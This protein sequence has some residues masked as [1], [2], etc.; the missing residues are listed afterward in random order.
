MELL[1]NS[2]TASGRV[3]HLYLPAA[4]LS[5]TKFQQMLVLFSV[6][7]SIC[8]FFFIFGKM[9]FL[10]TYTLPGSVT[11]YFEYLEKCLCLTFCLQNVSPLIQ[12]E[13]FDNVIQL[14]VCGKIILG[15]LVLICLYFFSIKHFKAYIE[16]LCNILVYLV[17]FFLRWLE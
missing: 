5:D 4:T 7:R 15:W 6:C 13:L 9:C 8:F 1:F 3:H 12:S 17:F 2:I 16:Y 10:K 11:N 14:N